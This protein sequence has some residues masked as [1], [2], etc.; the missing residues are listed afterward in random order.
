MAVLPENV[1]GV[2]E[3]R[4]RNAAGQH[5]VRVFL[6]SA[7]PVLFRREGLAAA[8]HSVSGETVSAANPAVPGEIISLFLT[9]LGATTT[10]G[11]LAEALQPPAAR[12]GDRQC[13]VL[14]AGRAPTLP[15]VDQINCLL[16]LDI[17][18]GTVRLEVTSGNRTGAADLVVR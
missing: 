18:K 1:T 14:Y 10:R 8:V 5:S 6:E 16:P 7:F 12:I 15:G 3:L 9:G 2:A 17:P 13:E 11:G 4:L